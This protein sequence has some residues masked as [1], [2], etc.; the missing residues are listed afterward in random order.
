MKSAFPLAWHE[1]CLSNMQAYL[2]RE[3]ARLA[4]LVAS[5][6]RLEAEINRRRT[7]IDEARA[8]G[9]DAFDSDKFLVKKSAHK[10]I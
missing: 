4:R 10:S 3:Q 7:Q 1:E 2:A 8:R 9:M 6:E 5:V